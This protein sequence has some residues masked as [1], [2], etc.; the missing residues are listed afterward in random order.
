MHTHDFWISLL[1][2]SLVE[3]WEC[4]FNRIQIKDFFKF[5]LCEMHT[6]GRGGRERGVCVVVVVGGGQFVP[7]ICFD[8]NIKRKLSGKK[9]FQARKKKKLKKKIVKFQNLGWVATQT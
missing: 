7:I 9:L 4:N 2:S 6:Y 1:Y 3:E 5:E 8:C